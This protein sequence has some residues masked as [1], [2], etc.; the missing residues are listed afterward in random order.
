MNLRERPVIIQPYG[1]GR[2][3][4]PLVE[5][6]PESRVGFVTDEE[7][8][9]KL[10]DY[11]GIQIHPHRGLWI[12]WVGWSIAHV[13][14]AFVSPLVPAL[15]FRLHMLIVEEGIAQQRVGIGRKRAGSGRREGKQG[16]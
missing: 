7:F 12:H 9:C 1:F 5:V 4:D 2:E 16:S 15:E 6:L 3:L 14:E 13:K 10:L 8:G 11:R